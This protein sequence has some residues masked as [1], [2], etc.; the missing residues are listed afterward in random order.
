MSVFKLNARN[1][2]GRP[3]HTGIIV[4]TT[5]IGFTTVA[6]IFASLSFVAALFDINNEGWEYL[7]ANSTSESFKRSAVGGCLVLAEIVTFILTAYIMGVPLW[8]IHVRTEQ[9][10]EDITTKITQ[11]KREEK[12]RKQHLERFSQDFTSDNTV[13]ERH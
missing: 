7:P 2:R 9:K 5:V 11:R 12:D 8:N 3:A 13:T 6:I 4:S 1:N 10:E